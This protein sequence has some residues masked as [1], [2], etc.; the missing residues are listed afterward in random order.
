MIHGIA[1]GDTPAA[2]EMLRTALRITLYDKIWEM[3]PSRSAFQHVWSLRHLLPRIVR[4]GIQHT[5]TSE[6]TRHWTTSYSTPR[7]SRAFYLSEQE[8]T[9]QIYTKTSEKKPQQRYVRRICPAQ[10]ITV[11]RPQ[12]NWFFFWFLVLVFLVLF[13]C[14][15]R[16]IVEN[17]RVEKKR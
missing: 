12:G 8:H 6:N 17:Q 9:P 2:I 4:A 1:A 10:K 16:L 5:D 13:S 11:T 7:S 3:P 15:N 14:A